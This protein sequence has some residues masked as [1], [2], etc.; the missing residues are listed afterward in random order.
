MSEHGSRAVAVDPYGA[1]VALYPAGSKDALQNCRPMIV[2]RALGTCL[3]ELGACL[4]WRAPLSER[5]RH[6]PYEARHALYTGTRPE[7]N[8]SDISF[9]EINTNDT[10]VRAS[11]RAPS[12]GRRPSCNGLG[13]CLIQVRELRRAYY[14]A[15]TYMDAQ[16]GRVLDELETLGLVK[17]T[18]VTLGTCPISAVYIKN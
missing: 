17:N 18:I 8:G 5:P 10:A 4:T 12:H 2:N 9:I 1:G 13:T 6:L 16:L 11:R 15:V 3:I 7:F 14:A